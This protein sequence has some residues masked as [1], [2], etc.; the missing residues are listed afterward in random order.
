MIKNGSNTSKIKNFTAVKSQPKNVSVVQ[1]KTVNKS[2]VAAVVKPK[3][4]AASR[5]TLAENITKATV[6]LAMVPTP[7]KAAQSS[8]APAKTH[9]KNPFAD[10]TEFENHVENMQPI[11]IP[12]E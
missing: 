2:K 3:A 9:K 4:V 5:P 12:Q 8:P 6:P 10:F 1:N 7:I 11:I